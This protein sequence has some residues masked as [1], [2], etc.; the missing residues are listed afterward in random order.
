MMPQEPSTDLPVAPTLG[1][2]GRGEGE[3]ET[4]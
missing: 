2:A 1:L 3:Q 4:I